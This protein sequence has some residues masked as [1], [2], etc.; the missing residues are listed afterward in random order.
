MKQ[1]PVLQAMSWRAVNE[2]VNK[3]SNA[4]Y[5]SVPIKILK[6]QS[7]VVAGINYHMDVLVGESDC[8]KNVR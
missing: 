4:A 5:H 3:Q 7:Q 2:G 8:P 1:A 6:A